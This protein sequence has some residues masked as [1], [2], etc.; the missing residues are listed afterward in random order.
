[1]TCCYAG[2]RDCTI[3]FKLGLSLIFYTLICFFLF[4]LLSF[5][6]VLASF[7]YLWLICE[8]FRARMEGYCN[9]ALCFRASDK[10]FYCN[11]MVFVNY[12]QTLRV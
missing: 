9:G 1:M 8:R 11:R 2:K 3:S 7:M 12:C 10:G 6:D 5:N 4:I